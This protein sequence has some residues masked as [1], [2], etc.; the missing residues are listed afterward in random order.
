[1]QELNPTDAAQALPDLRTLWG[2]LSPRRPRNGEELDEAIPANR[3]S[4]PKEKDLE[5]DKRKALADDAVLAKLSA[6]FR[7][8]LQLAKLAQTPRRAGE[9]FRF[10][11]LGDAEPGRF[12]IFRKLFNVPGVFQR[13]LSAVQEQPVDF[14][15]QLG[16]MVSRGIMRN[17]LRF[18]KTLDEADI[19]RPYLTVIGNHDRLSPHHR[20]NATLYTQTFG[21]T[22]YSFEHGGVRFV[23]L[24]TSAHALTR[25]QLRWLDAVLDTPRTKVVFTHIPPA[26]L[27]R[28]TD[29][30]ASKGIGGFKPGAVE[31]TE[32][33]SRRRV[34]RVYLGHIHGFG[35]QDF[36]GVRYVLTGGGGSPL[37]PSGVNDKFHHFI[38]ASVVD[39]EVR[40]TVHTLDRGTFE[41]P[42]GR[43]LFSP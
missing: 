37:F 29:F 21:R 6:P 38:V 39:G 36:K 18:F 28:W 40:E 41:I 30:G 7:T 17:Y 43:V 10:A 23:C 4:F 13:Q 19:R 12:W 11:V 1:M 15:L 14:S 34:S 35:V 24:D 9:P 2:S 27:R 25:F 32:I 20:S 5:H 31:L 42:S 22:N 16:D 3:W 33:V 26:C 8:R